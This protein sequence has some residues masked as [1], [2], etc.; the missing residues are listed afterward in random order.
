MN[1]VFKALS[2]PTRRKV[3]AMLRERPMASGEIAAAFD[4]AWPTMT[5]HLTALKDAGLVTAE[6]EG[7]S[8]RYRVNASV[9]EEAVAAL[10]ELMGAGK[11]AE[12][13]TNTVKGEKS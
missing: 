1:E 7:T 10:M 9:M 3:L 8:I 4:V 13:T 6:R 2:H 11:D 5:T 12:A